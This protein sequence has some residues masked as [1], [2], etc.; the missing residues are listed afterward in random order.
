VD[1][2]GLAFSK[3]ANIE[4]GTGKRVKDEEVRKLADAL[5]QMEQERGGAGARS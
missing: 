1:R 3:I 2:T 5:T 4:Q